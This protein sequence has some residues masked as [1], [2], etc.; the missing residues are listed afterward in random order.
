MHHNLITKMT[1]H[2]LLLVNT[3]YERVRANM[4]TN[5]PYT[6]LYSSSGNYSNFH[7]FLQLDYYSNKVQYFS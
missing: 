6:N 4:L 7:S 2:E 5:N 1:N 3:D